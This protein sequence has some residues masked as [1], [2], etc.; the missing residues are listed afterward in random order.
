MLLK[1]AALALTVYPSFAARPMGDVDILVHPEE[2]Q[3][4]WQCLVDAGWTAELSGG[5]K[6]YEGHHHLVAL[7]D[8]NGLQLV[9]EVHRAMLPMAGPFLLDES[10]GVAGGA[11]RFR[12]GR[13][14]GMGASSMASPTASP[15]R[16]LR[17]G[18]TCYSSGLGRTVRDVTT[19]LE[20]EAM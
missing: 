12:S 14:D 4:A 1:G 11:H 8:P 3:R 17:H 10:R 15:L 19:L 16:P 20:L 7:K 9:L 13:I 6:F 18:R 5:E 2:A